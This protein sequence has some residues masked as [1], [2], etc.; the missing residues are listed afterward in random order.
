MIEAISDFMWIFLN[1]LS[2]ILKFIHSINNGFYC[3][4][5]INAI[6]REKRLKAG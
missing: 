1:Q 3:G 4:T 5:L 6:F 2:Q